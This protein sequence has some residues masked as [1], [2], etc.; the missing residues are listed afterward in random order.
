MGATKAVATHEPAK[1]KVTSAAEGTSPDQAAPS[2][3]ARPGAVPET[4]GHEPEL[5]YLDP[6]SLRP[7]PVNPRQRVTGIAELAASIQGVGLL[8]PLVVYPDGKG[9]HFIGA[10]HRRQAA[11]V[12]LGKSTA[13][14]LRSPSREAALRLAAQIVENTQRVDLTVAEEAAA[15]QQLALMDLDAT[16]IA[17]MVGRKPRHV[18]N[19]LDAT[20]SLDES[21]RARASTAGATLE[22]LAAMA[23]ADDPGVIKTLTDAASRGRGEFKHATSR[24]RQD[25]EHRAKVEATRQRLAEAGVTVLNRRPSPYDEP[26]SK[27]RVLG[28]LYDKTGAAIAEKNHLA[29]PGHA[30]HVEEWDARPRFYCLDPKAH[31]HRTRPLPAPLD[32]QARASRRQVIESNAAWRAAEPVRQEFIRAACQARKSPP[33]VAALLTRLVAAGSYRLGRFVDSFTQAESAG[34]YLGE[35]TVR[36]HGALAALL[37][38][39]PDARIGCVQLAIIAAAQEKSMSVQTW[40]QRDDESI[41]WL[42]Y[43][44]SIGYTLSDIEAHT[45]RGQT[46]EDAALNKAPKDEQPT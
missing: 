38:K 14:C 9:G 34:Q 20:A 12:R 43:L 2:G 21:T 25:R 1:P 40:R 36:D 3:G 44:E 37:G 10:G 33:G 31:G 28:D 46:A 15:Y 42:A 7:D 8:I 30:A 29:C 11:L 41:A 13:P 4:T 26:P 6:A 35:A 27:A 5:V 16:A 32:E 24:A 39:T 22:E 17:K 23:G 45:V 19:A 18:Q